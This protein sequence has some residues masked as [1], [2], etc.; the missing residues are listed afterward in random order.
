MAFALP[1]RSIQASVIAFI[2]VVAAAARGQAPAEGPPPSVPVVDRVLVVESVLR[3]TRSPVF[4][5]PIEHALATGTFNPP[6]EG[7]VIPAPTAT[8]ADVG[9]GGDP[10]PAES[11]TWRALQANAD[12]RFEDR[13]LA[14]GYAFATVTSDRRRVVMLEA[15]G[16]RHVYVGATT[17]EGGSV[18]WTLRAGDVY[19]NGLI[20]VPIVL[21]QGETHLLFR[22]GRGGLKVAFGEP[23][24]PLFIA[25]GDPTLPSILTD[26][27]STT[28]YLA[29]V[30]VVNAQDAWCEGA[31]IRASIEGGGPE[32]LND[33]PALPP[34]SVMKVP[35]RFGV[36]GA[37]AAGAAAPVL[38]LELLFAGAT[39]HSRTFPLEAKSARERHVR[40]FLSAIDGSVQYFAVVPPARDPA[41]GEKLALILSL[42]GAS[43]EATSQA[44]AY[45]PKDWAWIVCP[46]NRR[47][48]GFDWEDWGRLD[49]MEVLT[50]AESMF[51]TDRRRTCLTGHSMGGHG[52]WQLG[53]TYPGRFA[54]IAPSAGWPDFWSYTGAGEW[55][56]DDPVRVALRRA[57]APSRTL[58]M[59]DR[60]MATPIYIL[61]GDK[62]D[63]V[64]VSMAR[65]MVGRLAQHTDL[66]Y[67][68]QPE[69]GHWWG[70]ECV[71]WPPLMEFLKAKAL[72][73]EP[74]TPEPDVAINAGG[75]KN[76][77]RGNPVL[78]YST[79]GS[80]DE[81]AWSLA[82]ARFDSE[83]FLYRGN[84]SF[85]VMSDADFLARPDSA[86]AAA[87][88]Y[89]GPGSNR[90]W[91]TLVDAGAVASE[92]AKPGAGIVAS[93][94]RRGGAG[95]IGVVGGSDLVGMRTTTQLPYFVSGVGYPDWY[96]LG[97]EA[98]V[99]G[100]R[101]VRSA[102]WHPGPTP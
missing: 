39:V 60:L 56:G 83:T 94:P 34:L 18:T 22:G 45:A 92:L 81:N 53:V 59:V 37:P 42:H 36:P 54:A 27:P 30:V 78:V 84:G 16:H 61:H 64:P 1:V 47:P 98:L 14:G 11:R 12:G 13:A 96:V 17:G 74:P 43:V 80:A 67:H 101:G 100:I 63:N 44:A 41:P 93:L 89:G 90:A 15:S 58:D 73:A 77:F 88:L 70:N 99:T 72:A 6:V 91:A 23:P 75:F 52:T 85:R 82:K 57:S 86:T 9:V 79:G 31:K 26:D 95:R 32:T 71:D 7:D 46:T 38:K 68:E 66:K 102:G 50:I 25:S 76:V 3:S 40:T 55:P 5:D 2:L 87:V 48:F 69:A 24:A 49:A 8:T 28:T 10:K 33:L 62:D 97:P 29:G 4:V 51:G 20:R 21:E 35:V 65:M 19:E